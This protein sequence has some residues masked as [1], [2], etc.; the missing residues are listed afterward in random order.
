[1]HERTMRVR[2]RTT[3]MVR[4][5]T[6]ANY[7]PPPAAPHGP[8]RG[9]EG[10]TMSRAGAQTWPLQLGATQETKRGATGRT[11][12]GALPRVACAAGWDWEARAAAFVA[13]GGPTTHVWR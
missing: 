3:R 9:V 12:A 7:F 13:A 11:R 10:G 5:L 1:M 2:P 8:R 6:S 4:A